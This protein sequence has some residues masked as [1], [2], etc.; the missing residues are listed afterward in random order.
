MC[1]REGAADEA[2]SDVSHRWKLVLHQREQ[3]GGEEKM[4]ELRDNPN[5]W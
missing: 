5:D 2:E 4:G 3:L 1:L